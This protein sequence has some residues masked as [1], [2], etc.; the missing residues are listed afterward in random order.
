LGGEVRGG[1]LLH[2]N[3]LEKV[4]YMRTLF[5]V[6]ILI[7]LAING[8]AGVE[9]TDLHSPFSG[10]AFVISIGVDSYANPKYGDLRYCQSDADYFLKSLE[11]DTSIK[12]INKYIFRNNSS[13]EDLSA[14]FNEVARD[15]TKKD[16]FIFFY[17]GM[18]SGDA[19]L[20]S[21]GELNHNEVFI[22]SQN[23]YAER[24]LFISDASDGNRF[25][26]AFKVFLE[27][28]PLERI[29]T[30]VDRILISVQ[31]QSYEL[32]K[33]ANLR[34]LSFAGGQLTGAIANSVYHISSLYSSIGHPETFWTDFNNDLHKSFNNHF[35]PF[36]DFFIFSEQDYLLKIAH[37]YSRG[38]DI[39]SG[40]DNTDHNGIIEKGETFVMIVGNQNFDNLK[41]L[42]NVMNDVLDVS[43]ILADKYKTEIVLLT[44]IRYNQFLDTLHKIKRRFNFEQ[45]SQILFVCASHGAKDQFGSGYLCFTDTKIDNSMTNAFPL[46]LLRKVITSF[47][48]TNTLMVMDICHSGLAFED[49]NCVRPTP[50]Q[51][52]LKSPI[53]NTSFSQ[54]SPAYKNLLN[55]ESNLYFGSSGDQEAADG[56][57]RNSPFAKTLIT[58]LTD[59]Q[60][61]VVDSF[62]LQNSIEKGVME[63]GAIS[64]P[65]F[66]SY[67][68]VSSDGRF[69]FIRK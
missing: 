68:S 27:N 11:R 1:V 62:Y 5:F 49:N 60:L 16:L 39:D 57:Y 53:F 32:Q 55:Q 69:L 36:P 18:S 33:G 52:P 10:R 46:Q 24:Q 67:N 7:S 14:A 34:D 56:A 66:C 29:S 43:Q 61:P 58:F 48:A 45:G 15:V 47:G 9:I 28:K 25:C 4:F 30:K 8:R 51:I 59:N 21:N 12:I 3:E 19:L 54:E 50:M 17:A 2:S 6:I 41:R 31:S 23:I 64:F 65:V 20:L 35:N 44:D 42:P 13:K 38:I 40:D 63:E 37:E 26:D 22:L